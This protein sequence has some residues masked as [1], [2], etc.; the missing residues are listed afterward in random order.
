[1]AAHMQ[2]VMEKLLHR[3]GRFPYQDDVAIATKTNEDHTKAVL[4]ILKCL[5]YE[6]GLRLRLSKCKFYQ[7]SARV[8]GSLLTREGIK[9]DPAKVKSIS[10]WTKPKDG[11][12]IQ[13]FLGAAG[14]HRDFSPD[15]ARISAPLEECRSLT[16]IDWTPR[17]EKA[18]EDVK[19]IFINDLSLRYID[20]NKKIYLTT[21]ASL[22]GI[23]AGM[24]RSEG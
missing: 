21:D 10:S 4:E 2:R 3:F 5:T 15:Y 24:D 14:F 16:T 9:M 19:K 13:C 23:G 8:L 17:R 20:W 7:Q 1:M 22:T 6:A 18:F 12:D 11:K